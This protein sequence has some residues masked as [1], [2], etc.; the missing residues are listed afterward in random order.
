MRQYT[1]QFLVGA[2]AERH[3][4]MQLFFRRRELAF[5]YVGII[6]LMFREGELG[7]ICAYNLELWPKL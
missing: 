3:A 5:N 1:M 4:N 2:G 6:V 7:F